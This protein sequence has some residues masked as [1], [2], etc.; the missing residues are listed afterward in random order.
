MMIHLV[1]P[2]QRLVP[3][4]PPKSLGPD[5]LIGKLDFLL[6]KR[7]VDFVIVVFTV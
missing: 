5:I 7:A 2:K 6:G 4:A 3:I 1:I